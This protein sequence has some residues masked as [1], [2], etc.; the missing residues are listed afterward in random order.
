MTDNQEIKPKKLT[1]GNSKLSLNKSFDS[2]TGAQ[3]FVNAKSKTLV[4]VRKSSTGSATT[5]SLNKE[6]NSL[7][8]TVIDANKEEFNRRLS[9]LKKLLSNLN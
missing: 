7:D 6:R 9:I 8:Q 2:L 4:E 3:S 1:L 5:L